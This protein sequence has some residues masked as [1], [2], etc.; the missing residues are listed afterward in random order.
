MT[1]DFA[2]SSIPSNYAPA[3][4]RSADVFGGNFP[5]HTP[6]GEISVEFFS[7]LILT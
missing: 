2:S 5:I 7:Y 3:N 4:Y 6:A 1:N